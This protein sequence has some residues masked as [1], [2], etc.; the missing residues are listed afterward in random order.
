MIIE[1][2][3]GKTKILISEEENSTLLFDR[4]TGNLFYEKNNTECAVEDRVG[5]Q[6]EKL[7]AIPVRESVFVKTDD[8]V[9]KINLSL[10]Q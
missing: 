5:L 9:F 1:K 7:K 2:D 4:N 8:N 3:I 6:L 10:K